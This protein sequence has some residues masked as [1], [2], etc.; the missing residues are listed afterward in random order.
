MKRRIATI[1]IVWGL[2][3]VCLCELAFVCLAMGLGTE[4]YFAPKN[5]AC[6][7]PRIRA[8]VVPLVII[9]LPCFLVSTVLLARRRYGPPSAH[10]NEDRGF[11]ISSNPFASP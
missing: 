1:L 3:G 11:W 2:A 6:E 7:G 8:V 5:L 9:Y 10:V 4:F